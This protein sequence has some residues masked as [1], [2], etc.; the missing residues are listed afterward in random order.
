MSFF[1]RTFAPDFVRFQFI[2]FWKILEIQ[3]VQKLHKFEPV[4]I[5]DQL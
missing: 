4:T 2:P 3:P 5:C 1:F